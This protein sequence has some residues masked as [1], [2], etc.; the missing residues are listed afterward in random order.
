MKNNAKKEVDQN[1]NHRKLNAS[2]EYRNFLFIYINYI[3]KL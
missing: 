1:H 3:S 2:S